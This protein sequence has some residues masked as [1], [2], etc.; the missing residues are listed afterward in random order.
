MSHKKYGITILTCCDCG[1]SLDEAVYKQSGQPRG[2][3]CL[4]CYNKHRY[5]SRSQVERDEI[6]L[7][8]RKDLKVWR[9]AQRKKIIFTYGGKCVCCGEEE[10]LF[11]TVDH[12]QG[13]RGPTGKA[14]RR[15]HGNDGIFRRIEREGFPKDKYRVLCFNCNC[16]IGFFKFCP[17][18]QNRKDS[19]CEDHF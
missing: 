11:L 10:Y 1:T 2:G 4:N 5:K 19:Q 16:A 7:K 3:R 13:R 6:N 17:H 18:Q 12:I 8:R 14:D 9:A 15:E